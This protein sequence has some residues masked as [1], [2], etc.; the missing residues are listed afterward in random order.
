MARPSVYPARGCGRDSYIGNNN[1]GLYR[2]ER[3]ASAMT[4]GGFQ[5]VGSPEF[6]LCDLG[7]KRSNYHYNGTG[8]DS[9]IG[10]SNGGFYP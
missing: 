6:K 3:P 8:R 1:G 7:S 9:Y 10:L 5:S 4:S 2:S